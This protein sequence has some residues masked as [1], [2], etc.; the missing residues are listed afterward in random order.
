MPYVDKEYYDNDYLGSPIEDVTEF[1]RTAKRSSE[2]I[3]ELTHYR[4]KNLDSMP[5][6]I[7][8][9]VKKAVCDQIEH[10]VLSGG[11]ES[12][13]ES[14]SL[15]NVIIG[16][17]SYSNSSQDTREESEKAIDYLKPTGL[18]YAGVFTYG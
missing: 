1:E 16:S 4:I 18:L 2:V 17:F 11:Y 10:Y 6:F 7:Q 8:T 14:T 3:D 13:K 5:T 12:M 9:Q 15:G